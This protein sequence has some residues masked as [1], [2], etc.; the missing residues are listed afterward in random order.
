MSFKTYIAQRRI[1]DTPAGDFVADARSDRRLPD[2]QTWQELETYLHSRLK[3]Y[4]VIAAA[5]TVWTSFTA[6]KRAQARK[7]RYAD[8]IRQATA[9][10]P[11]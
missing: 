7:A 1:T 3:G 10:N 4:M 6:W 11:A 2:A 5:R 8:A 9:Q